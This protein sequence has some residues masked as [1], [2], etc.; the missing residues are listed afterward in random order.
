[1]RITA[2]VRLIGA[3]C[4]AFV[5]VG[6]S[7]LTAN[8]PSQEWHTLKVGNKKFAN[9]P[10]FK[11]QRAPLVASQNP[12]CVVLSCS[13]SRVP[14]ELVFDQGL[15]KLFVVRVAGQV[16]D[17]IVVDSIEYAVGHFD[18]KTIVVLGHTNCGAVIGA[19]K[20]LKKN[21]GKI[22]PNGPG[23]LNAVLIPIEKAIVKAHINIYAHD[24]L[25]KSIHANIRYAA[26]QLL[27]NSPAITAALKSGKINIV[28]GEY[29][30]KTGK[31]NR[32]FTWS[33]K[34]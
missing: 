30:L 15:G 23:H 11:K 16:V 12:P 1:M 26:K 29:S 32:H 14:P 22:D 33:A 9:N 31:V 10:E 20:H 19:L 17:D 25:K 28:G 6:S 2:S 34:K 5:S 8:S 21:K 4:L 24:A 18:V 3:F 27:K 7:S 13:D